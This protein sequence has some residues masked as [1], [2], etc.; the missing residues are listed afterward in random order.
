MRN[1][2][3]FPVHSIRHRPAH[4]TRSKI[5]SSSICACVV[6]ASCISTNSYAA[7]G[8]T[9]V[10]HLVSSEG[11][12]EVQ[13]KSENIWK[14]G[15]LND[16][17]CQGDTVRSAERSRA[18]IT[19][20]NQTVLRI[21]QNTA[22]QLTNL[23]E[24][25]T[26][27]SFIGLV[28]GALQSFSR[29]PRRMTVN[30][31]YLNGSIEGTEFVFRVEDGE[32]RLAVFEGTVVAS[33][34]QG[35]LSVGPG[36]AV[37]GATGKPPTPYT[38]V[39]PRDAAQWSLYYPPI[40]VKE[41]P[42]TVHQA[43]QAL[44]VGR[45]AE[46][47]AGID[48]ALAQNPGSGAALALRA[49][50]NVVQNNNAAA[51]ADAQKAVTASPGDTATWIALSYAQQSNNQISEAR[52]SLLKGTQAQPK[53]ALAWARLAELHLMLGERQ[54]S[55]EAAKTAAQLAPNLSRT[56]LASGYAALAEFR[57]ADARAAFEKAIALDSADPLPHLGLGLAKINAG[58]LDEGRRELEVAV[59]LD[60]NSALLRAYLGKA[61]FEETRSPLDAEQFGIAKQLDPLDP[62]AYLYDGIRKQT[63][64]K[65]IEAIAEFEKSIDLNDNRA[66]YRSRLLLDKD[67]AA[68]G[69]S[70]AR[71]YG[72]LGFEEQAI[73]EASRS[74]AT[75]P[76]N[77]SAHRFLAD[78]YQSVRRVEVARVSEQL[79]A[80]MLQDIN[81]QPVQPSLGEANLNIATS[82]GPASAGF[83][84]FTPLFERNQARGYVS[85]IVGSDDTRGG[86]LA[87]SA[88]YDRLSLSAGA[89]EY[90]TDGWRRLNDQNV[91][92]Y[93][94]FGQM[95]LTNN[96]NIQAEFRRRSTIVGDLG[97]R[98]DPEDVLA[99][100]RDD[101]QTDS[102]R[103]GLRYSP[104]EASHILLSYI[105]SKQDK[106][107][108]KVTDDGFGTL[109]SENEVS[110]RKTDQTEAQYIHQWDSINLV[111]GGA[112]NKVKGSGETLL[113]F[114][115][116]PPLP[117]PPFCFPISLPSVT[118][119]SDTRGYA[120]A[121][122]GLANNLVWTVGASY[123]RYKED[124]GT[125]AL[126]KTRFNPKLGIQ[127]N[128]SNGVRIRAAAFSVVKPAL[129]SNQT[130]EPTQVAG[131]NQLFDDI[132]GTRSR[133]YAAAIDW[134]I[135]NTL[136]V[137][138][139]TSW[140]KLDEPL[141][142]GLGWISEWRKEKYHKVF[143]N[144]TPTPRIA[145]RSQ[146]IYDSYRSQRGIATEDTSTASVP[147]KVIT[148]S[149]PVALTYFDPSG[150]FG[151]ATITF[152]DQTVERSPVVTPPHVAGKDR[153][154][155]VDGVVG[156]KLG[157]RYGTVSL[158]VRNLLNRKFNYQDDS[159][160]EF[161]DEPSTG[162][163]FPSRTVMARFN[164][165][166]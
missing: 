45:V 16:E 113:D 63:E 102:A 2:S 40:M 148:K 71:A 106:R 104:T 18:A 154:N 118:D 76:G 38:V 57:I 28:K 58:A 59:A 53:D 82:G 143:L 156:Y 133:R 138:G 124:N 35:K 84:E 146:F 115:P 74:L 68:R 46:A 42:D 73:N 132:S 103:I 37:S 64:N 48:Q 21:D 17:L 151:G 60:S 54:Q 44:S 8:C 112:H 97:F 89:L 9:V 69:A 153:F 90:R 116:P 77:T 110:S 92:V 83:N 91:S 66:P 72:D 114:N 160:R 100:F 81:I 161:R 164:L 50:I 109:I 47:R 121:N 49:V 27:S 120:Y 147:E 4:G 144:W 130:L 70:L 94:L 19:L 11:Q 80:Q 166:F 86:E 145:M 105:Q 75:D 163:Y 135:Q 12:I 24:E 29:K 33:N 20:I 157:K 1:I 34:D 162:P 52:D 95:A 55:T 30:T 61:Y 108:D 43:A 96:L 88:V 15:K 139:E 87:A 67:R 3:L 134:K 165:S 123:G 159:Y 129:A 99:A 22:V 14:A 117:C 78:S 150:F 149:L 107:L 13:R 7:I 137:G 56:Q 26:E 65:P 23:V 85:G 125:S 111:M 32:T 62:T 119:V 158:A 39:R 5:I 25:K 141:F 10:G 128:A 98:F 41:S 101:R 136:T 142:D 51:L 131:F 36:M 140:R 31:P 79:Q 122:I 127:W 6:I 155:V 93:N 126:L 152:V